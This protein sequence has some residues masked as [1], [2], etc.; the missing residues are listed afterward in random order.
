MEEEEIA[1]Q[2]VKAEKGTWL[3]DSGTSSHIMHD[4]SVLE[5]YTPLSGHSIKGIGGKIDAIGKGK[6]KLVS[7]VDEKAFPIT[8]VNVLYAPDSPHN[9]IS[10]TRLTAAGGSILQRGN[11]AKVKAPD[12]TVKIVGIKAK[13]LANLYVARVKTLEKEGAGKQDQS[14]ISRNVKSWDEW[15]RILGHL[16]MDSVKHLHVAVGIEIDTKSS[17]SQQCAACVQSKQH[18]QPFPQIS[19]I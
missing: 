8:L 14:Y 11:W 12:G 4:K 13:G 17:E 1:L 2:A 15:H 3:L 18:V 19:V 7:Y 5:D 10:T 6:I 16:N 9:L